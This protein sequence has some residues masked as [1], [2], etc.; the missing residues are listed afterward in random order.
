MQE[1]VFLALTLSLAACVADR[2]V[3]P[4][5]LEGF[6]GGP[7]EAGAFPLR[8]GMRWTFQDQLDTDEEPLEL[9]IVEEAGKLRLIGTREEAVEIRVEK[10][11]LELLYRGRILERPLRFE[12]R[13]G[14]TWRGGGARY[15]AYGYDEIVVMGRRVRAL[16]VAADR[17]P[18]RDLYWFAKD[19]GWIRMRTERS[20]R[21]YRDAI[22]SKFDPGRAN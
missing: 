2:P 22:L 16:V 9:A 18:V 21:T 13:I 10:G 6:P 3:H 8:A 1:R 5:A 12:G 14:D 11:H 15:T 19:M 7:I 20:G 4:L 17:P